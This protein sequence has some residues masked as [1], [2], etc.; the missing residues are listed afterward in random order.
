MNTNRKIRFTIVA[1]QM[2]LGDLVLQREQAKT[3]KRPRSFKGHVT[4]GFTS[5]RTIVAPKLYKLNVSFYVFESNE[6]V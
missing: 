1:L 3:V 2:L 4:I 5:T 6:E